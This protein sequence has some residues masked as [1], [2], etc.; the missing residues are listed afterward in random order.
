MRGWQGILRRTKRF[1][2]NNPSIQSIRIIEHKTSQKKSQRKYFG[3]LLKI[4]SSNILSTWSSRDFKFEIVW[5]V[6]QNSKHETSHKS[7]PDN[8]QVI[9]K[10]LLST[11]CWF[12]KV[13][14][15]LGRFIAK[16]EIENTQNWI[17]LGVTWDIP[18]WTRYLSNLIVLN[19]EKTPI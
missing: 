9:Q 12:I 16:L 3:K 2:H 18:M 5:V 19:T 17:D 1:D 11:I 8:I 13:E 6:C 4:N 14:S 7:G 15:Y 10:S